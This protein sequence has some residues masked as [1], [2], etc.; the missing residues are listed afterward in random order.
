M[1]DS[2]DDLSTMPFKPIEVLV[3]QSNALDTF[4]TVEAF[5]ASGLSSG[6]RCV[7]EGDDALQYARR[8][9]QHAAARIPD[10][11]LLDLGQAKV[12]ELGVVKI[13]KSNPELKDIPIV[14]AASEGDPKFIRAVYALDGTCFIRK[15]HELSKLRGVIRTC[16]TFCVMSLGQPQTV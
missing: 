7:S 4:L 1:P 10:L 8:E 11:I 15:P 5:K 14:V 9:G 16:Y 6:L 12:S 3:V 2:V 13:I